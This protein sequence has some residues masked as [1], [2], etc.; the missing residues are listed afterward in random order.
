MLGRSFLENNDPKDALNVLRPADIWFAGKITK[1][2]KSL[3]P[4]FIHLKR[5]LQ[6]DRRCKSNVFR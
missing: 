3:N 6:D 5:H 2:L 1:V 4:R